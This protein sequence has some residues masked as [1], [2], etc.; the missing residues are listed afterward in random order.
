MSLN[1]GGTV[2][3]QMPLQM[4]QIFFKQSTVRQYHSDLSDNLLW[5]LWLGLRLDS[6]LHYFSIFH[7]E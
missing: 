5:K 1:F 2:A 3:F 4:H 6:E 7:G